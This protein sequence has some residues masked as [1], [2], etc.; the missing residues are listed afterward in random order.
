MAEEESSIEQVRAQNKQLIA[1]WRQ[2]Y[3]TLET[4]PSVYQPYLQNATLRQV[5]E[6]M[7]TICNWLERSRAPR[8]FAP[9]FHLARSLAATSLGNALTAVQA[10]QRGEYSFFPNLLVAL[11]HMISALHSML[12]FSDRS[13]ARDAVASLGGKLAES[14]SLLDT[15]QEELAKKSQALS[16]ADELV[17]RIEGAASKIQDQATAADQHVAEITEYEKAAKEQAAAIDQLKTGA[18]ETAGSFEELLGKNAAL[19]KRLEEQDNALAEL[20]DRARDQQDLIAALLPKG[21]SAGLA[22]AFALRVGQVEWTKRLWMAAFGLSVIVLTILGYFTQRE[23]AALGAEQ[24]TTNLLHR[25]VVA[26][27]LVWLGW[28]SAIQ[29]GNTIRVQEDYAFKEATSKAFAGYRDHLE[30]LATVSLA[31]GYSAMNLLAAKTIEVLSN[32][33]L[34]LFGKTDRDAAPTSSIAGLL[35]RWKRGKGSDKA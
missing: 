13:E 19:Q 28:F 26:G 3:A 7:E 21:A 17:Q 4:N 31:E 16:S 33:P 1:E 2:V 5:D 20:V 6:A 35:Q 27:P 34:R 23:I 15:A 24:M 9:T 12:I 25:L 18:S 11:N 8:G 14:L 30:H 29:Y 32:D 22:S 10:L